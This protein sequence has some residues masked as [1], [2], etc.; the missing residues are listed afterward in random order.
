VALQLQ[1]HFERKPPPLPPLAGSSF[2]QVW[3]FFFPH[4]FHQPYSPRFSHRWGSFFFRKDPLAFFLRGNFPFVRYREKGVV[5][6]CR[7]FSRNTAL[8]ADRAAF[9]ETQP[10]FSHFVVVSPRWRSFLFFWLLSSRCRCFTGSTTPPFPF[11]RSGV[12]PSNT[13]GVTKRL[14]EVSTGT[15]PPGYSPS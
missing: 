1:E 13:N 12:S 6:M 14:E 10:P 5:R 2:F 8:L 7:L 15:R 4:Q 3:N 11:F 9:P